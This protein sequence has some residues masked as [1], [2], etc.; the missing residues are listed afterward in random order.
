MTGGTGFLGSALVKQ[1][2]ASGHQT[3]SL[4]ADPRADI[5]CDVGDP[6]ALAAAVAATK[7]RAIVHLAANLTTAADDDPL[8]AV[9]VNALGTAALF[10][11]AERA[12]VERIVYASSNAAV[13]PCPQG[14]GDATPL[15]PRS[16]YGVTKAF[17][18]QLA[19]AMSTRPGAPRY[20]ALRF[21]W[22]YGPGR[23][24]GWRDLQQVIEQVIAGERHVRYPD[25]DD[26]ID[27][28][29]V[30]DAAA[31]LAQS[32]ERRLPTFAALNV[33][34]DRRF[35]RDA[36]AHLQ[37]RYPDLVA[38]PVAAE[39]PPS[40]WGLVNDGILSLLGSVPKT[41][42]EQGLDRMIA[43]AAMVQRNVESP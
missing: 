18:E 37:C 29:W 16:I 32:V 2:R 39:T 26:A 30:D 25:L 21:G 24:R 20:L 27:W 8:D 3:L 31:A 40:G 15:D 19:R 10:V 35:V 9:R 38:E 7:P 42:L 34:G 33:V 4:D 11:A 14:S 1:A 36:F 12:G 41:R 5:V 43:A 22:V 6:V 23:R 17:G 13:G 28:T